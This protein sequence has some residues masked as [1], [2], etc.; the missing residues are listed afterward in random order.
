MIANRKP[1]Y[2]VLLMMGVVL[3][4]G[5][6]HFLP[7]PQDEFRARQILESLTENNTGLTCFKAL[8]HIRME[9][10]DGILSGRIAMAAVMPHKLR[11]EWLN[12]IGQPSTSLAGDGKTISI[13]SPTDHKLHR[14]RQSP[15]ALAKLIQIPIG[16]EDFQNIVI[17]RP[18][19]L[20]DT[21]AQLK[22]IQD[23][24]A[25]LTLINRWHQEVAIIRVDQAAD[26]VLDMSS[27]D[28]HGRLQYKTRWLQWRNN[29]RYSLPTK[30]ILES[31]SGQRLCLTMD[32]FW[33]DATV[34]SST[35][36]LNPKDG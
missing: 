3:F 18:P 13:W 6:A 34:P 19:L 5:C 29:G 17:G 11:V 14:F 27:F 24:V 30:M 10:K 21:V 32:R 1:I 28:G 22:G 20:A 8:A 9:S 2:S 16:I 35:F 7:P 36:E 15:G 12:M 26:R 31:D 33:P 23:D 4:S 25:V